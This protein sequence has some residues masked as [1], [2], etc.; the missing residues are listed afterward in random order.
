MTT[1]TY[2]SAIE[3]LTTDINILNISIGIIELSLADEYHFDREGHY[4]PPTSI[5]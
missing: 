1:S 3:N 5:K 4:Q 2:A